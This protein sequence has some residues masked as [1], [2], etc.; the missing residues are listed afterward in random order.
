MCVHAQAFCMRA[1]ANTGRV[2]LKSG[3][4]RDELNALYVG[5]GVERRRAFQG[6]PLD[7]K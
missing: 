2:A 4:E 1:H 5:V 6:V 7:Q 3:N